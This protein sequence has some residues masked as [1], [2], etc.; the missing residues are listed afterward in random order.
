MTERLPATEAVDPTT[1]DLDRLATGALVTRLVEAN[2]RAVTA[3]AAA[4]DAI[5]QA[6]DACAASLRAGGGVVYV[7]AGTS[8]RLATLDAAEVLPTFGLAEGRVRAI[9]A[10]GPAALVRAVE[11]AEDDSEAGAAAMREIAPHDTVVGISASGGAPFVL[12]AMR[13]ARARGAQTVGVANTAGSPLAEAV[14]IAIVCETGAEP[15]AGST[16]LVAG[17][18]QKLVLNALSTATMVRLGKTY[19]NLMVDLVATN[20]K[21]RARSVRIVARAAAIEESAAAEALAAADGSVKLAIVM[22]RA[23]CDRAT[24]EARLA[25]SDGVVRRALEH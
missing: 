20:A 18:A 5:A 11:G 13:A 21:L 6:V 10:G 15:L 2:A 24:A 3:V 7:G 12:G 1:V 8:G 25:A 22:H 4:A 19:E 16:R 17:T 14:A 23:G 9:V